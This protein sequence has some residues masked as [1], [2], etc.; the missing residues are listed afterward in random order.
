MAKTL[1]GLAFSEAAANFLDRMPPGKIRARVA[2]TAKALIY[3]PHPAGSEKMVRLEYITDPVWRIY[4]GHYR[5]LYIIREI[6]VVVLDIGK[7]EGM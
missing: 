1:F 2:K 4:C 5:I 3:D 7:K 6:E